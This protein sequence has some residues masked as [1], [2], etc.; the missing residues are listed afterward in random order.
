[1]DVSQDV[2]GFT[3][4]VSVGPESHVSKHHAFWILFF[5]MP[6]LQLHIIT[7]FSLGDGSSL[8]IPIF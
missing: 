5:D 4:V 1:M 3:E 2:S 8:I 7:V 6:I